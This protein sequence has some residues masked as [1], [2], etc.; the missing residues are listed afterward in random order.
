MSKAG[1][2]KIPATSRLFPV[3]FIQLPAPVSSRGL[4]H[5]PAAECMRKFFQHLQDQ[6][7]HRP[8]EIPALTQQCSL[9]KGLSFRL[10]KSLFCFNDTHLFPEFSQ[11]WGRVPWCNVYFHTTLQLLKLCHVH[12]GLTF[13]LLNYALA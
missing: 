3:S 11:P 6:P 12:F 4:L 10:S 7:L 9:F 8:S 2:E 5:Q 13:F 1:G